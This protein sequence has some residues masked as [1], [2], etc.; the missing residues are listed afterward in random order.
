[1]YKICFNYSMTPSV[2]SKSTIALIPKGATKDPHIP[3]HYR[4]IISLVLSCLYRA[5]P[6]HYRGI[7]SLVLSCLYRAIALHYRDIISRVLS[8]LYRAIPLFWTKELF[9][10]VK[11]LLFLLMSKMCFIAIA[12]VLITLEKSKSFCYQ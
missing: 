8:C 4:G 10:F 2:W 1:M 5:I 7:I 9:Y 3:L 6:L 12:H 11:N